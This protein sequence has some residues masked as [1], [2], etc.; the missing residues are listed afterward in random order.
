MAASTNK[1]VQIARFDREPL[2]G[3][4]NTGSYRTPEGLEILQLTGNVLLVPYADIKTV[5]F[6]REFGLGDPLPRRSF[7]SRPK[8][9][10]LWIR[11]A[12]RDG[13]TLEA[14]I[15]NN[16]MTLEG[17]GFDLLPPDSTQRVF[18]PRAA[19]AR[20]EVLGVVGSPLRRA[21]GKTAAKEQIGLFEEGR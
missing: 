21:R 11:L 6:V 7:V 5:V 9:D 14:V 16:L 2:S 8:F 3:F 13:D 12:F 19:V 20:I 15:P 18:V 17:L 1:K 4:V 10:G